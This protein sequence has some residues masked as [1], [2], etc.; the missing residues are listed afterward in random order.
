MATSR[1]LPPTDGSKKLHAITDQ[2][3]AFLAANRP[4]LDA[5]LAR[6]DEAGRTN[7]SSR[8][9]Q[10]MRA[11]E[12]LKL[13][14]RLRMARGPLTPKQLDAVATA[15]DTAAITVERI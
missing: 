12:N 7:E 9:P 3:R 14:L 15:L 10:I 2:G 5:L 1:S 13:A 11:M 4:A 8:A 6:M